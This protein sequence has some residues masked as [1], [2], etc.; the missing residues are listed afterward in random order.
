MICY[1]MYLFVN[2]L[3]N[4][5]IQLKTFQKGRKKN[6]LLVSQKDGNTD[7]TTF[8]CEFCAVGSELGIRQ[9]FCGRVVTLAEK[10]KVREV[11][12]LGEMKAKANTANVAIQAGP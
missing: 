5:L 10:S 2:R 8:K 9:C 12:E 4:C 7:E 1:L 6:I 3:L 11:G